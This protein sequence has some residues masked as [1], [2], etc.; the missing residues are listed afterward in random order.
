MQAKIDEADTAAW[1]GAETL[2]PEP[3]RE[4]ARAVAEKY[5]E[6]LADQRAAAKER[7]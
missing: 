5:R 4:K 2:L 6:A 7:H 3:Q 1:L